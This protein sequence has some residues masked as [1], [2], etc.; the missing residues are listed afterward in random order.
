MIRQ[1]MEWSDKSIFNSFI[2]WLMLLAIAYLVFYP[3]YYLVAG[4]YALFGAGSVLID[5]DMWKNANSRRSML[6]FTA[7]VALT[8]YVFLKHVE[9]VKWWAYFLG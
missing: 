8:L 4:G 3:F 1:L 7:A 5:W 9:P 6:G 2:V